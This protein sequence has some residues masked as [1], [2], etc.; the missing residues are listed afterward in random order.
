MDILLVTSALTL[1]AK[2]AWA[3]ARAN[4]TQGAVTRHWW[5]EAYINDCL[6]ISSISLH[7]SSSKQSPL[8]QDT[9][10]KPQTPLHT[11]KCLSCRKK[12][13]LPRALPR[14]SQRTPPPIQSLL[15]ALTNSVRSDR[16]HVRAVANTNQMTTSIMPIL[17]A[18]KLRLKTT[19]P[20]VQPS[21]TACPLQLPRMSSRPRQR[22]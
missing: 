20:R 1:L 10:Y 19:N 12:R 3:V 22:N 4:V 14:R 15:P 6:P 2:P 13:R 17:L 11:T 16:V 21:Q 8:Q 5:G 7:C 18:P 9:T